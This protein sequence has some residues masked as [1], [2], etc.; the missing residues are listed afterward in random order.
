MKVIIRIA[1]KILQRITPDPFVIAIL[2]TVATYLLAVG[3]TDSNVQ[4]SITAWGGGLWNLAEFTLKMAMILLGGFVVAKSPPMQASLRYLIRF[5]TTP[6]QAVLFCTLASLLASWINWGFGLVIGGVVALEVAKQVPAASFRVLVAA[7]YSGFLVWHAGLSGSIPLALN[8][9]TDTI[10]ATVVGQVIPLSQSTF[11]TLNLIALASICILLPLVNLLLMRS[12]GDEPDP[13]DSADLKKGSAAHK[14][15]AVGNS[16]DQQDRSLIENNILLALALGGMGLFY[17]VTIYQA[18]QFKLNLDSV[19][20]IFFMLGLLLHGS[21]R[22]FLKSVE[23]AVPKIAPILIQYPLYAGIMALLVDTGLAQQISEFFVRS[24][25]SDTLP[26]LAFYSAGLV[27]LFVPSGGGQWAV[28]A[29]VIIP[30]VEQLGADMNK[31]VMAVAW[32]D[33]WTN[34]LQPFWAVPLLSIAG[35]KIKDI[36]GLLL[37]VLIS[38]GIVLSLIFWLV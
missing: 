2:L 36:I 28:Q 25:N 1:D 22:A 7:S 16:S 5:I 8:T 19:M 29:P 10:T 27:N 32:G 38:S 6:S 15:P 33:A 30:A 17:L 31:T 24:A 20:T 3:T 23:E 35:L 9:E 13:F 21:P 37:I 14:D 12:V 18:G 4:E 26:L 11:G 34:M